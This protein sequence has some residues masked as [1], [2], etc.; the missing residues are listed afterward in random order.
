[1]TRNPLNP[2]LRHQAPVDPTLLVG[3]FHTTYGHPISDTPQPIDP[4]R[5]RLR[6]SLIAEEFLELMEASYPTRSKTVLAQLRRT[7][8]NTIKNRVPDPDLVQTADALADLIY[9]IY[10]YALELG[11]PLSQILEEVHS[12]NMSK[13]DP[14]TNLPIYREDGKVLKGSNFREPAIKE[15]IDNPLPL[16]P[17]PPLPEVLSPLEEEIQGDRT[18]SNVYTRGLAHGVNH[19]K[20]AYGIPTENTSWAKE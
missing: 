1:M 9:V 18:L 20:N 5:T 8:E 4:D 13:L 6:L 15:I 14:E 11:L 16:S 10:G 7:V 2:D 17:P 19:I 12:S 3:E